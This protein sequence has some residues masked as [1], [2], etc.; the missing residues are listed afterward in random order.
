MYGT[1]VAA[2]AVS[3]EAEFIASKVAQIIAGEF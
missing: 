2:S 3:P 1:E